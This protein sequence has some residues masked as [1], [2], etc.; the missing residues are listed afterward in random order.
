MNKVLSDILQHGWKRT[1]LSDKTK[2]SVSD[3]KME[4]E[5]YQQYELEIKQFAIQFEDASIR[6]I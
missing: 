2:T 5:R 4:K 1:Y 3:N 6:N